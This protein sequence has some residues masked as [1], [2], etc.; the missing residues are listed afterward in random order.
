MYPLP[1]AQELLPRCPQAVGGVTQRARSQASGTLQGLDSILNRGPMTS[2]DFSF[3]QTSRGQK[4][5]SDT[6]GS[7]GPEYR[8]CTL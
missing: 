8:S 4:T 3:V 2:S 5:F 1:T 7:P 6:R